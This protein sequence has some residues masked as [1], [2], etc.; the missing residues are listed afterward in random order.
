MPIFRW[1]IF[2]LVEN[3]QSRSLQ[4][5]QA[6]GRQAVKKPPFFLKITQFSYRNTTNKTL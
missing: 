4:L 6:A 5:L 1:K 3:N 2:T